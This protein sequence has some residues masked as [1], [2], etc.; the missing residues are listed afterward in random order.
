MAR[1][2][3]LNGRLEQCLL[4]VHRPL[5][6]LFCLAEDVLPALARLTS[7]HGGDEFFTRV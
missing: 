5:L 2:A 1:L 7:H 4:A 3:L 6:L